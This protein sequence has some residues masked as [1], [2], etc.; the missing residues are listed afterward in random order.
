MPESESACGEGG[1]SF[2]ERWLVPL[3]LC[4]IAVLQFVLAHTEGLS[5]WKGGGFGMFASVDAPSMRF[6]SAEGVEADGG[7]VWIDAYEMVSEPELL[8]WQ[9]WP[10]PELLE[11]LAD[12][13]AAVRFVKSGS[14]RLQALER[15]REENPDLEVVSE[16]ASGRWVRP[17]RPGDPD[18]AAKALR[19]VRV[20]GW[21]IRYDRVENKI[22][23]EALGEPVGRGEWR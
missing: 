20:C 16:M 21:R 6:L 13:M 14:Q 9:S 8:R 4:G 12:R 1:S 5:P 15:F 23:L 10:E 18:G 7:E 11:Q 19:A 22:G 17:W 2:L 3:I